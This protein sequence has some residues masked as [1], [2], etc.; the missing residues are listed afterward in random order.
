MHRRA[1]DNMELRVA[2]ADITEIQRRPVIG[3]RSSLPLRWHPLLW[4]MLSRFRMQG[5]SSD[6]DVDVLSHNF[7]ASAV[8]IRHV[9]ICAR[10][11]LAVR[12]LKVKKR[13][14]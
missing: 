3:S 14:F 7:S 8:H 6:L 11:R 10:W 4:H 1:D 9:C 13:S 2:V 12:T 5:A